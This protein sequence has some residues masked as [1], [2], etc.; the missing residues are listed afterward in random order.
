ML[1]GPQGGPAARPDGSGKALALYQ[2]SLVD[3]YRSKGFAL[4]GDAFFLSDR[5]T[6]PAYSPTQ[7]SWLL[8]AAADHM[9]MRFEVAREDHRPLDHDSARAQAWRTGVRSS[10][11]G[12][13]KSRGDAR[14]PSGMSY[15]RPNTTPA[16]E[17]DWGLDWYFFNKTLPARSDRTGVAHL[18]YGLRGSL[19]GPK[20]PWT[21]VG[22][23]EFV[24]TGA[25][26]GAAELQSSVGGGWRWK[27]GVLAVTR[28]GR[29]VLDGPGYHSWWQATFS[30]SFAAPEGAL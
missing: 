8:G 17:G 10:W 26:W 11:G 14:L 28:E 15:I 2:L 12:N 23:A 6:G 9:G 24:T 16:L 21:F 20:V 22:S 25:R 4:M 19:T 13:A 18:R 1:H 29:D 30:W 27:D 5:R 7:A 3:M